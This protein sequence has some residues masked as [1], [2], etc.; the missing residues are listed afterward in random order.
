M[1]DGF[2]VVQGQ[3]IYEVDCRGPEFPPVE[4]RWGPRFP[5]I[6]I[7][8]DEHGKVTIVVTCTASRDADKT[9]LAANAIVERIIRE[10]ALR[11]SCSMG[12]PMERSSNIP[13][14][15]VHGDVKFRVTS[16]ITFRWGG[17]AASR[18][19]PSVTSL[20]DAVVAAR[21][22]NNQLRD[23]DLELY[24][25]AT[26][27]VD[28][29]ARFIPLY[30]TLQRVTGKGVQDDLDDWICATGPVNVT[31]KPP[32]RQ[33]RHRTTETDFTRVR[34]SLGHVRSRQSSFTPV[35]AEA[36]KLAMT[37]QQLVIL[38]LNQKYPDKSP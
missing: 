29:V 18:W 21:D 28:P 22:T 5:K 23:L 16:G 34:N 26:A 19:S 31:L 1:I 6:A 8:C 20:H 27:S 12:R 17:S 38:A 10:L 13:Y 4:V 9:R 3:I 14:I 25:S 2:S 24:R 15:D 7:E 35:L 11:F 32:E 37:L 33:N 36:K 30:T